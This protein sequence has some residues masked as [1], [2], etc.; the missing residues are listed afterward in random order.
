MIKTRKFNSSFFYDNMSNLYI[1]NPEH[2]LALANDSAYFCP[3]QTA[4]QFANEIAPI[5]SWIA[6]FEDFTFSLT[7]NSEF[8]LLQHRFNKHIKYISPEKINKIEWTQIIPWGWNTLLVQRLK[9][10]NINEQLLPS[11][12]QLKK[13]RQLSHRQTACLALHYLHKQNNYNFALP[14]LPI[15]A[16]NISTITDMLLKHHNLVL[17]MPWS[18]SGKGL[19]WCR[20]SLTEKDQGW[21]KN[22]LQ[23]QGGIMVEKRYEVVQN[24]ALEFYSTK[25]DIYFQGYSIFNTQNGSYCGNLLMNDQA[26]ENH[27][28]QWISLTELNTYKTL[29]I[30]FL[31]QH[32]IGNYQ[33]HLGI[34][35]FIYQENNTFKIHPS[36]EIN[37]RMTMGWI[38]HQLTNQYVFPTN[39][40]YLKI[41]YSSQKDDLLNRQEK[42]KRQHPLQIE[43]YKLYAGHLPLSPVYRNSHYRIY[44]QSS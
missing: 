37:L 4:Q 6:D 17:K 29:L 30:Q 26:I 36:V 43:N 13:I 3:P 18:G 8:E 40:A 9:Q 15:M 14:D 35:M 1:F 33:G 16:I 19:R 42:D 5:L 21:I 12:S 39:K 22:G 27:L 7:S 25:N 23:Q 11:L 44:M 31:K 34:D 20:N 38:A 28:S 2:D 41:E 10:L 32:L 24:F